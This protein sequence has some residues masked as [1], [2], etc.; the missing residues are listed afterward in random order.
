MSV[1]GAFAATEIDGR[2]LVDGGIANNIP[3]DRAREMGV[4]AREDALERFRREKVVTAYEDLYRRILDRP[5]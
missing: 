3:I 1:P 4:R 2:L 5:A